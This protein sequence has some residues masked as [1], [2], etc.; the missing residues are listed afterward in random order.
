MALTWLIN[1]PK[2]T[3]KLNRWLSLLQGY[4][5]KISHVPG[6]NNQIAN[7]LSHQVAKDAPSLEKTSTE[8]EKRILKCWPGLV[9]LKFPELFENLEN[10][11]MKDEILSP[12]IKKL[13]Q[14]I[15]I[16]NY[17]LKG[18]ILYYKSKKNAS[19]ES[20]TSANFVYGYFYVFP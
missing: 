8:F 20:C 9:L 5:F 19:T 2:L 12:I 15:K 6:K 16:E 1:N 17:L 14:K 18:K 10:Y 7:L 3:G 4:D 11:Q 13:Q